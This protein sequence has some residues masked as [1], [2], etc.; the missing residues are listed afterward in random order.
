MPLCRSWLWLLA[1]GSIACSPGLSR[2]AGGPVPEDGMI[3][4]VYPPPPGR[5]EEIPEQKDASHVWINGQWDW[6]GKEWRWQPG[7]W[8]APPPN[9]YFTPWTTRRR[10]DGKLYFARAAWREN[11]GRPLDVWPSM[12]PCP[13]DDAPVRR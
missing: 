2:P 4:V 12:A 10:A 11:G 3:E 6:D 8:M 9:A 1:L 7:A 5:V 13:V